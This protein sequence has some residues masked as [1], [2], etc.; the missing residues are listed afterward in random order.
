MACNPGDYSLHSMGVVVFADDEFDKLA[1]C[2]HVVAL[3]VMDWLLSYCVG[4]EELQIEQDNVVDA[5]AN[6]AIRER[7]RFCDDA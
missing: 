3:V 7:S 6:L 1:N 4:D 2:W 5:V